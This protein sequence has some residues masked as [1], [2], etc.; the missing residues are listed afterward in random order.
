[1]SMDYRPIRAGVVD[2]CQDTE[3]DAVVYDD[4]PATIPEDVAVVVAWVGTVAGRDQ[5]THTL[6]VRCI[7]TAEDAHATA[8]AI[9]VSL[10]VALN[11]AQGLGRPTAAPA[12][13]TIG[14][15]V[16]PR[17]PVI[18]ITATDQPISS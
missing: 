8:D 2:L 6:E 5:W 14:N 13:I 11:N 1:M 17:C 18:T 9:A 4:D 16:Y 3:P 12:D 10:M 7:A 15:T